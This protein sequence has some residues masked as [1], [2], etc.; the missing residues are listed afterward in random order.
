MQ[1]DDVAVFSRREALNNLKE[2]NKVVQTHPAWD[3]NRLQDGRNFTVA[4]AVPQLVSL[5][6]D[7]DVHCAVFHLHLSEY[8][9]A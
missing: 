6:S 5:G 7:V 1:H 4:S 2:E 8:M 9:S 3:T